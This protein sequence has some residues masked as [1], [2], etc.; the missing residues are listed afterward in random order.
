MSNQQPVNQHS[1]AIAL[2]QQ[3]PDQLTELI[4]DLTP[5]QLSTAYLVG[6][7]TVA[8]NV[9]HIYDSHARGF[10]NCKLILTEHEPPLKRYQQDAW[11]QLAD[12]MSA[13]ISDS[14]ILIR[15][16]HNRWI[17]LWKSLTDTDYARGGW[18]PD[19]TKLTTVADLLTLYATHG[20]LHADQIRKTLAAGGI[21]R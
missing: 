18:L 15:A 20:S 7:W 19:A 8:Q 9:H 5:T 1:T 4:H 2:L 10:L 11:A 14:L 17:Q 21:V 12:G 16:L 6:E 13:D 3:F